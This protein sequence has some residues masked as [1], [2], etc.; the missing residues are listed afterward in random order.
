MQKN[1]I[2]IAALCAC[3]INGNVIYADTNKPLYKKW[4]GEPVP[5]TLLVGMWTYHIGTDK[6][7]FLQPNDLVGLVY[8]GYFI[9]TLNN[10][11]KHRCYAAGISRYWLTKE[12]ND[13]ATYQLGYR[14]G[15]IHG[16]QKR[17]VFFSDKSAVVPFIQII[18]DLNWK[19]YGWE[20]STTGQVISTGFYV[21]F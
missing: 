16:Y 15:G 13:N 1:K 7:G 10:S 11:F 2:A 8:K 17:E 5:P 3:L 20:L 12:L 14:I 4:W 21:R 18:S 6:Y 19:R 9:A